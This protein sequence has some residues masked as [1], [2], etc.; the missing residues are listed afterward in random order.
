[1]TQ[2]LGVKQAIPLI[3]AVCFRSPDS[4]PQVMDVLERAAF[5]AL[6]CFPNQTKWGDQ[7]FKWAKDVY[8]QDMDSSAL[9]SEIRFWFLKEL[10]GNPAAR[11]SEYLPVQLRYG[12]RK[13][14]L[15]R[16]F[17]TTL[18]DYGYPKPRPGKPDEEA[19]WDLRKVQIDHISATSV[20]DGI[21]AHEKDRLGNLTALYGP[22]NAALGNTPFEQKRHA[23]RESPFRMTRALAD[24]D[25]WNL[26][27]M[28][29]RE[30]QLVRFAVALFCRDMQV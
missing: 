13:K 27:S 28:R 1:M 6:M 11:L 8:Q 16:Y 23:Y 30:D 9:R 4:L 10:A 25:S 3:L 15:L 19:E 20:P 18:N 21:P 5:V 7:L 22:V 24:K 17:L 26:S 29:E 2:E 12:G 14:T